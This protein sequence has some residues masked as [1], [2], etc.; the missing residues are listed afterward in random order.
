MALSHSIVDVAA[1]HE[2][3]LND[4]M[5]ALGVKAVY[6]GDQDK[7]A[8]TPVV[9]VEPDTKKQDYRGGGV[10]RMLGVNITVFLLVY[11]SFVQ[12][13][14][15]NRK[16]ADQLAEAIEDLIH[17]D[18]TLGGLVIECHVSEVASGYAT[19]GNSL[20]RANRITIEHV[21]QNRLPS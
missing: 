13:A 5:N 8:T 20:V 4:N 10:N 12:S 18:A 11:H 14:Q 3:L 17:Q 6:Y 15:E 2:Q 16:G 19:K 7:L 9:C 21:T 1:A